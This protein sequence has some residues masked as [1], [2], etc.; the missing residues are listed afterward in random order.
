VQEASKCQVIAPRDSC[1]MA[2]LVDIALEL[3]NIKQQCI[4]LNSI[5]H[6][7]FKQLNTIRYKYLVCQYQILNSLFPGFYLIPLRE[8]EL[9]MHDAVRYS[10][11]TLPS[12]DHMRHCRV[13]AFVSTMYG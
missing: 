13:V 2:I 3:D 1:N 12:S 10:A 7:K 8:T 5:P 6:I 4:F 9:E 11:C